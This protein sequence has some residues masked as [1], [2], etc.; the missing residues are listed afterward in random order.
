MRWDWIG[1]MVSSITKDMYCNIIVVGMQGAV[2]W[3]G[4]NIL[5][6]NGAKSDGFGKG[7]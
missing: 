2:L 3:N 5:L 7:M 6:W 4:A 1:F